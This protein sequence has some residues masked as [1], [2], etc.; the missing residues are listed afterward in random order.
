MGFPSP[1]QDY[2]QPRLS[3][4]SV[5]IP[6]LATTFRVDIPDGFLLVDSAAKV[7][8]GNRIAYQWNGYSGLGKMYRNS[9]VTEESEVIEGEPLNDV[10]VLGKVTCEV[11]LVYEEK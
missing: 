5:F 2:I 6:N 1:A 3:L 11:R 10:I 8:P 7:K 4:N 9:L